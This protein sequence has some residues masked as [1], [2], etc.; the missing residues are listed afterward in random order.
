MWGQT[1]GLHR[2]PGCRPH[3]SGVGSKPGVFSIEISIYSIETSAKP[4]RVFRLG[5]LYEIP[6]LH[7]MV[8]QEEEQNNL[9]AS[10]VCD[11]SK[12]SC[13]ISN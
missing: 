3:L 9:D 8:V 6:G 5:K 7:R 1:P 4:W 11:A 10:K 12:N 13:F 2:M